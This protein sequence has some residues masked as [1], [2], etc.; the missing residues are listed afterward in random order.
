MAVFYFGKFL[1][2]L[3]D[4]FYKDGPKIYTINQE[5]KKYARRVYLV[6]IFQ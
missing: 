5:Q 2:F 1:P 3:N 6:I 4:G